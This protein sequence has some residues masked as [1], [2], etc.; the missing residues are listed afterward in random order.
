MKCLRKMILWDVVSQYVH[1]K[2]A[3][4]DY[5]GLCPFHGENPP[6]FM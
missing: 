6:H 1:L 3:G 2:R 4:K 5:S